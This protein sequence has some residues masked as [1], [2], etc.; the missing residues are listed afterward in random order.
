ML[1]VRN[2]DGV[3][4]SPH[5]SATD[6]DIRADLLRNRRGATSLRWLEV[7]LD[8]GIEVHGQIVVCPGVNDGAALEDTLA[9][10][11]SQQAQSQQGV[12]T[13][14]EEVVIQSDLLLA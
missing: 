1:F 13:D 8:G 10:S 3:S 12:A 14:L 6:S 2:P 7:L 11:L 5:E 4:H 9:E